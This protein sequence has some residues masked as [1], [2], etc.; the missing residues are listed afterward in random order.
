ME[1]HTVPLDKAKTALHVVLAN[2]CPKA[3]EMASKLTHTEEKRALGD[4][5]N[6]SCCV[7]FISQAYYL[8]YFTQSS[9]TIADASSAWP[10]NNTLTDEGL[11]V[12]R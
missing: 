11:Q 5:K 2:M 4:S 9:P 7:L 10:V 1:S 6:A 3:Y 12:I 8:A